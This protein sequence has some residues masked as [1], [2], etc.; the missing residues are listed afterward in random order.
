MGGDPEAFNNILLAYRIL[1]DPARKEEYDRAGTD[2]GDGVVEEA[3]RVRIVSIQILRHYI[4]MMDA[5]K[6]ND[7]YLK[8]ENLTG[9]VQ[10]EFGEKGVTQVLYDLG[11]DN[12]MA[13]WIPNKALIRVRSDGEVEAYDAYQ[14][15]G[16]LYC[17][18]QGAIVTAKDV[19][20][21]ALQEL[22]VFCGDGDIPP[23]M[24]DAVYGT[25][26]FNRGDDTVILDLGCGSGRAS[27]YLCDKKRYGV[28]FG[29]DSDRK[30]LLGARDQ[31]EIEKI[32]PEKGFF[33]LRGD[34]HTLP[35]ME[36]RIDGVWWGFGWGDVERPRDV[37]EEVFRVLKKGGCLALSTHE[38]GVAMAQSIQ[39]ALKEVGFKKTRIYPP[40]HG[41]FVTY[42]FK[43]A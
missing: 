3:F 43:P 18:K 10:A 21:A 13:A 42:G 27:R 26:F 38:G 5:L 16:L 31:A 7:D 19:K 39:T 30:E 20:I 1:K 32:G 4:L 22:A 41:V 25:S 36:Q 17:G 24:R 8:L 11:D 6:W 34:A 37:L 2:P 40:R 14:Q 15:Y 29:F 9:T 12:M 23:A 33:L 35:F 28:V